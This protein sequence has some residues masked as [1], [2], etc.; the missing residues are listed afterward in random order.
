MLSRTR[1]PLV[2]ISCLSVFVLQSGS[3]AADCNNNGIDDAC[4]VSGG[5]GLDV[6]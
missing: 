1:S 5:G 3:R 6:Q 2:L 4:D